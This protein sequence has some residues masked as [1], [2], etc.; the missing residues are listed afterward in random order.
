[1]NWKSEIRAAH[2]KSC[3]SRRKE[4]LTRLKFEP[5]YVGSY[6]F[7]SGSRNPDDINRLPYMKTKLT[8]TLTA[9]WLAA[10]LFARAATNDLSSALQQGLFEEEANR[11]L[12]AAISAYEAVAKQFEKD[13]ALA[14]TA[15]F[16]LGECYR[17][18]GQTNEAAA[19]YERIL[20]DFADQQQLVTLSRQNLAGL[21]AKPPVPAASSLSR[22][23][24]QEQAKL[25]EEQIKLAEQDV[26]EVRKQSEVGAA[27]QAQVRAKEREVLILRQQ[28][29]AQD[30]GL[31]M[32]SQPAVSLGAR[33]AQKRLLD[34]EIKL[35]EEDL[36][37]TKLLAQG[38]RTPLGD[39]NRKER[40]V[41]RLR[42]QL[43]GLDLQ[44]GSSASSAG[45][46]SDEADQLAGHI[47]GIEQLK[48]DPAKQ[49]RA[50]LAL[51]PDADLKTMLLHLPKLQEQVARFTKDPTLKLDF[52]I[53]G[54]RVAIGPGGQGIHALERG[55]V[56]NAELHLPEAQAEV[57]DQLARISERVDFILGLQKAR[58][59][60]LQSVAHIA[61]PGGAVK[62]GSTTSVVIDDEETEIRR[63]QKMIQNSPDLINAPSGG[64]DDNNTPLGRAANKGQLR[65][66][67]YLLDSG[68][69][70]NRA[71]Q[72][73]T[74]LLLAA[75]RGHKAMIELLL[76]KGADVSA[77][78]AG[79]KTA[80]HIAAENGFQATAETLA[81]GKADVNARTTKQ[82]TPLQLAVTAGHVAMTKFLLAK[83]ADTDA[84]DANGRTALMLAASRGHLE[85]MQA[86]LAA[87]AKPDLEDES[88]RTALSYA[89]ERGHLET[90]KS[91]LAAKADP[92]A[93]KVLPLHLA[94]HAKAAG[95][96][97]ALLEAGADAGR[98]GQVT[99]QVRVGNTTYG[100][101]M[102]GSLLT[103][104][105]LA[106]HEGNA[107]AVKLLLAN[108]ADPNGLGPD[109]LPVIL[110]AAW[111]PSVLEP[112][113]QA[114][115]KPNVDD[116]EGR[117]PLISATA[118]GVA[119][120]V[121]VL[122]AHGAD[123]EVQPFGQTPLLIAVS[124][125][126][127]KSAEVLLQAGAN[128]NACTTGEGETALHFAVSRKDP[129]LTALLLANKADVNARNR[130]GGTPLDYAKGA[131][132][133]RQSSGVLRMPGAIPLPP[134]S[135]PGGQS[136]PAPAS[137]TSI[138]DLLRE[139]GALDELPDF[140]AIR[141]TRQGLDR[142]IWV[143]GQQ[144]NGWNRFTLLE[145]ILG[146]YASK[147]LVDFQRAY[148]ALNGQ[149]LNP[150][151]EFQTR[152]QNIN[153]NA[154]S[155]ANTLW[156]PDLKRIIVHRPS[157]TP[158]GK[159]Q[160]IQ[161]N[162]LNAT[163][164]VDCTQD[165]PLEF[166]DVVEIPVRDHALSESQSALSVPETAGIL[167]CLRRKVQLIVR[168][169]SRELE[170]RPSTPESWL[171]GALGKSEAKS[172]LLS[173]SDLSRVKVTR[174]DPATG[175][176]KEFIVDV[177][178]A[179]PPEANFWL[180]DG[181]VIEVPEK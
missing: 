114:G 18:Q 12:P 139:H 70:V 14:A 119:E 163:N 120:S 146:L 106:I 101:G 160:E 13:R 143:F 130:N 69:E 169:Q 150:A 91:L 63:L 56:N 142:P 82:E 74:P 37:N 138:T 181:D 7:C 116:G 113:L 145:T 40:E 21:G 51:Y 28:L 67:Q 1:M 65:V 92:N 50:V 103:P 2:S 90:V 123:K 126:D 178:K 141:V 164:G 136:P 39:V 112:L 19:H 25:L 53:E 30:V 152:L 17:K 76:A 102:T 23:S 140:T 85:T 31:E 9:L 134:P 179:F 174:K 27:T 15:V 4:A 32:S 78:D 161:V 29:A 3:R 98:A 177:T 57:K 8:L 84:R 135:F 180:R 162:L 72:S 118:N 80:L 6:S 20:R 151:Q 170:L 35:A 59:Q 81:A 176:P 73:R 49:G 22:A 60:V 10:G 94:I 122:L 97:Q 52:R 108:K 167:G 148:G 173:S 104:L 5:P 105:F 115:A 83:G 88:G 79:G 38:G 110:Q 125:G 54:F 75:A 168:G 24:R 44:A 156:F 61:A 127:Q 45:T 95:V 96:V 36:A 131:S 41:L 124:R 159:E 107:E 26:A 100:S 166:G 93:G 71:Y 62:T 137:P 165:L 129:A 33:Q 175:Q 43:A 132:A 11:N 157:R 149:N 46:A 16:R 64:A 77:R 99:W 158:G 47:A 48:D 111:Q 58:L 155:S 109:R 153:N 34:D 128:V 42:Q 89:A 133:N 144:T 171:S 172:Q 121:G 68:A 87:G 117:T 147:G 55:T 86:L 154:G 66:A